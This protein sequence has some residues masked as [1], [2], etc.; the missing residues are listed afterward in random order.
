MQRFADFA[1]HL[2][3]PRAILSERLALL[4]QSDVLSKSPGAGRREHYRLTDKGISLW[5]VLRSLVA[6]GDQHYAPNGP[7]RRFRH[8][9]DNGD[10]DAAGVCVECGKA[11]AVQDYVVA[12]GTGAAPAGPDADV[13][14]RALT[15]PRR[16]L[17]PI[18]G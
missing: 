17:E 11:L 6:W 13:V 3:I 7:R 12:P 1:A 8:F 15:Q 16:L 2:S 14:T 9:A 10:V 4:V 5:P 18:T